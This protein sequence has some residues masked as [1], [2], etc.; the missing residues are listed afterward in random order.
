[1][2]GVSKLTDILATKIVEWFMR[3]EYVLDVSNL[4]DEIFLNI[5]DKSDSF[6]FRMC[7]CELK[8][9]PPSYAYRNLNA[10]INIDL[11]EMMLPFIPL[12]S[13]ELEVNQFD[14]AREID[15]KF[16]KLCEKDITKPE[17]CY[18]KCDCGSCNAYRFWHDMRS[19]YD[20]A[21]G[22]LKIEKFRDNDD[23]TREQEEIYD[24]F[25]YCFNHH[26]GTGLFVFNP[27]G[28]GKRIDNPNT[29]AIQSD[30]IRIEHPIAVARGKRQYYTDQQI[31]HPEMTIAD[32]VGHI[33]S[34]Y[35]N[36]HLSKVTIIENTEY[37]DKIFKIKYDVS[38]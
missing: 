6:P 25:E 24:D 11:L 14:S 15:D 4:P 35:R 29:F 26:S 32:L 23:W 17:N 21:G 37:A 16:M 5:L 8:K 31:L 27:Y 19:I 9:F 34:R 36:G 10:L 20:N 13:F 1:M 30:T 28:N 12:L 18:S 38:Y 22:R 7:V 3:D 33:Q 2:K